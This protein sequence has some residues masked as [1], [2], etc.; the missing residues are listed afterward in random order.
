MLNLWI[1]CFAI[2]IIVIASMQMQDAGD[3]MP[4][5]PFASCEL[6]SCVVLKMHF[7]KEKA[8]PEDKK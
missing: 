7:C 8:L 1:N 5:F 4:P 6:M 3:V 2:T